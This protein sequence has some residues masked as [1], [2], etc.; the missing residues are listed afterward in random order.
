VLTPRQMR[1]R[2][3]TAVRPMARV[4]TGAGEHAHAAQ[5]QEE[6]FRTERWDS[7]IDQRQKAKPATTAAVNIQESEN[8]S[9]ATIYAGE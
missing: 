1:R 8:A 4:L 6:H 7:R 2:C 9:V 3:C 5:R